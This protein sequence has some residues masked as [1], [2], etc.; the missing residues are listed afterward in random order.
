MP[1][2][3]TYAHFKNLVRTLV[4]R[5]QGID[6]MKLCE[7]DKA[8]LAA[9]RRAKIG[10][11]WHPQRSQVRSRPRQA[12]E[13]GSE[14][15]AVGVSDCL[16]AGAYS[17]HRRFSDRP[18]R[19]AKCRVR[20]PMSTPPPIAFLSACPGCKRFFAQTKGCVWPRRPSATARRRLAD[21]RS[22]RFLADQCSKERR[23]Q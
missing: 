7:I 13:G 16:S 15:G 2:A 22:R 8:V 20:R 19:R 21:R 10:S 23:T 1:Y 9:P 12:A 17:P 4:A 14:L 11:P 5:R 3:H 18:L 6:T